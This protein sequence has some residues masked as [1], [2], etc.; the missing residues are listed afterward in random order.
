MNSEFHDM[1]K[2]LNSKAASIRHVVFVIR[3]FDIMINF[4]SSRGLLK[5][6]I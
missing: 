1:I 6:E 4:D 2:I 5:L 3:E